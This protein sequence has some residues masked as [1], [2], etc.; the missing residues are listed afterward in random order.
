MTT[1][2]SLRF[3]GARVLRGDTLETGDLSIV[4]GR[5]H[6]PADGHLASCVDLPGYWILPGIVDLHG[7]A[8]E[9][10]MAPRP[11]AP[12]ANDIALRSVDHDAASNGVT[13]AWMAQSWSWEGGS[14]GPDFAEQFMQD[15]DAY[16]PQ[17][18]TDLRIQLRCET[19]TIATE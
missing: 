2:E 15:L 19:H 18:L 10:H 9:R 17:A 13:T 3:R 1:I 14:R 11:T 8:F 12:F 6:D 16:R 4:A 5:L 7:D